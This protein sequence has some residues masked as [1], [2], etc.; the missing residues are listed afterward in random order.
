MMKGKRLLGLALIL[1]VLIVSGCEADQTPGVKV[2]DTGV[3]V[4]VPGVDVEVGPSDVEVEVDVPGVDVEVG[5]SEAGVEVQAPGVDIELQAPGVLRGSGNMVSEERAVS[6]FD[7]V[8]LTGVGDVFITQGEQESLTVR[9]DDNLLPYIRTE[10]KDGM[11]TLGFTDGVKDVKPTQGIEFNLS[12]KEISHLKISGAGDIVAP[13]IVADNPEIAIS[14]AGDVIITS[15]NAQGELRIDL[16]GAGDVDIESLDAETLTVHLSGAGDV[17]VE[18]VN[19][20]ASVVRLSGAGDVTLAGQVVEQSIF[21]SGVGDYDATALGSQTALVE[22]SGVGDAVVRVNNTL[23]VRVSGPGHVEYYGDPSVS[24]E[25]TGMGNLVSLDNPSLEFPGATPTEHVTDAPPI[26]GSGNIITEERAVSDFER[27]SLGGFGDVFI[28]QG[29][30]ESLTV[31]A[32]DNLM[33]YIETSVK[34]GTLV[35]RFIGEAEHR[36]VRPTKRIKFN[37]GIKKVTGLEIGGV[38]DIHAP[39][40]NAESLELEIGGV[41]DVSI[42]TVT[43]D[44]LYVLIGGVGDVNI[45]SLDAND[46]EFVLDGAVNINVDALDADKLVAVLNGAGDVVLAGQVVEQSIFLNGAINHWAAG[47]ESHTTIVEAGGAGNVIVWV[48]DSLDVQ[49]GGP[50]TVSYYGDPQVTKDISRVGRLVSLGNP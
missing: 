31:E 16:S 39:S 35:L 28:T 8:S 36:D 33:P 42:S 12:M 40:L 23:D 45:N 15:L 18:S 17:N 22:A 49:I 3:E 46:L 38:G 6:D 9:A 47:L 20:T 50:S 24:H 21:L 4:D 5:V 13:S 41:G 26:Q 11:L 10:V 32:D 29:E 34:D 27:V 14:G 30:Q 37:V 44:D 25:I 7:C 43:V 1:G 19:A 2:S 48:T